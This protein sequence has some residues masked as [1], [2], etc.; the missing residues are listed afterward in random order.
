MTLAFLDRR[1]ENIRVQAVII[2]EL[3]LGDIERKVLFADLVEGADPAA[4]D[5]RPE[6]LNRVRVDA[7]DT[8]LPAGMTFVRC[9]VASAAICWSRSARTRARL[10]LAAPTRARA[11]QAARARCYEKKPMTPSAVSFPRTRESRGERAH[12][13]TSLDS[14]FRGNDI[15]GDSFK[16][17]HALERAALTWD[18]PVVPLHRAMRGPPPPLRRGG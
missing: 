15:A 5:Q 16:S 8:P 14:R 6:A 3:E 13:P 11:I 7:A 2:A 17:H 1:P 12:R 10:A 18:R 9:E 4:L